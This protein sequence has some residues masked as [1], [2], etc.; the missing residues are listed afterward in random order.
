MIN[1][2]SRSLLSDNTSGPKKVVDNLIKGLDLIGYPYVI[3]KRLDAC[4]RLWIHD[5]VNALWQLHDLNPTIKPIIGPNLFIRPRNI[6]TGLDL[7]KA[8]FICP[9]PWA[10]DF[11][12]NFGFKSCPI[13]CWPA[14]IDTKE[15]APSTLTRN[16]VLVYFK[17]RF[18]SELA[19][20]ERVLNEKNISY[21]MISYGAYT[22]NQYKKTLMNS[23]YIIWLGRHETQGIALEEALATNTPMIV[24]EVK[25]LGH[26][27]PN[28]KEVSIFDEQDQAF[29]EAEVA[30]YFSKEC[31]IK[32]YTVNELA[33]SIEKMEKNFLTYNP[34]KFILDNMSLEK[35]AQDF[36][37]LY[38]KHFGLKYEDGFTE[39]M[40]KKGNWINNSFR[41]IIYFRLKKMAK[42]T[43]QIIKKL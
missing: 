28:K 3:N 22:E 15:Y 4:E 12:T 2:I 43:L 30:P 38:E 40:L 21:E 26:W 35:Q 31:G 14:G 25:K 42:K 39:K 1:I 7:S 17:Q 24:W 8:V 16:K 33:D 6:P 32:I 23:R 37:L 29:N 5:D 19:E 41:Y 11:W 13:D 20:I 34:R 36:V 18:K 27:V 9:S 10:V